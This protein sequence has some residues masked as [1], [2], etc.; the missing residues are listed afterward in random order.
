[1]AE[2]EYL[3]SDWQDLVDEAGVRFRSP[4]GKLLGLI[5]RINEQQ[6]RAVSYRHA[7]GGIF[8]DDLGT[9]PTR[10]RAR[11]AVRVRAL[12]LGDCAGAGIA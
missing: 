5:E 9:F 10:E 7:P 2:I 6:W 12:L 11:T 4:E 8:I 1:M 3:H